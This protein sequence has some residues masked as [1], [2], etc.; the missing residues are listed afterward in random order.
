MA[1]RVDRERILALIPHRGD[2]LFLNEASIDGSK[3]SGVVNWPL[4]HP[5]IKG[6]FPGLPVVP[7]IFFVEAVAQFAGVYISNSGS[8]DGVLGVLASVRKLLMHQVAI[9]GTDI[10]FEVKVSPVGEQFYMCSGIACNA[11]G[12]KVATVELSVALTKVSSMPLL[13][14]A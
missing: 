5:V 2:A 1:T 8:E 6:H 12:K 3:V 9:P 13:K 14:A 4:E 10:S 7:G 11:E